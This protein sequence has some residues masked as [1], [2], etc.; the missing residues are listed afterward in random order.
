VLSTSVID[1]RVRD[2]GRLLGRVGNAG[3]AAARAR[4][5]SSGVPRVLRARVAVVMLARRTSFGAPR[6]TVL[7]ADGWLGRRQREIF[8]LDARRHLYTANP[9]LVALGE[10]LRGVPAADAVSLRRIDCVDETSWYC[11]D[12]VNSTLRSV[13]VDDLMVASAPQSPDGTR[14][15][16]AVLRGWGDKTRF[17][18]VDLLAA[19]LLASAAAEMLSPTLE[20]VGPTVDSPRCRSK[21]PTRLLEVQTLLLQGHS[22]PWIA[23]HL[24]L[25][26]HTVH[27]HTV[28]LYELLGIHSRAQ[29]F[30]RELLTPTLT[31]SPTLPPTPPTTGTTPPQHHE[32]H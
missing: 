13:D 7:A 14:V 31:P 6:L 2:V 11:D 21:L 28:R 1:D 19:R 8:E 25:S 18:D 27:R 23:Q 29:L 3:E 24:L 32:V 17:D 5:L 9:M 12:Y 30:A 16:I 20:G 15:T 10:R 22:L 4:E 26:E